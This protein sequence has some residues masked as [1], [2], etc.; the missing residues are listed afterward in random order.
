M[1]VLLDTNLCIELIRG[2]EAVQ[3]RLAECSAEEVVLSAVV[4]AE[5]VY[6]AA[7]SRRLIENLET[8]LAF[9]SPF[10]CWPFDNPAAIAYGQIRVALERKGATIGPHDLLIAAT[11]LSRGAAVAT[12]NR[13]EF[14]RIDGLV[15]EVW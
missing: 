14:E 13:R 10:E 6:G 5:L 15:V 4:V 2:N 8:T 7:R 9:V 3:R 1:T 12:R 11:A